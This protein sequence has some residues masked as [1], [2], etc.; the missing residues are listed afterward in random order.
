MMNDSST[1][2][3]F[4]TRFFH[5]LMALGFLW[6]LFTA[7]ARFI[8]EEAAL[9]KAVFKYHGQMGFTILWLAVLR[10]V[11]ALTQRSHRPE[12]N[13][14][15]KLGHFSM[16][17]LMVVVPT[18]AFIR[19]IGGG[20]GFTYWNT[21]PILSASG[22]KTQ[23]M[24]DLGNNFHGLLGWVLFALIVGHVLMA[25]KHRIAGGSED[26]LPRIIGK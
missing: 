26:V 11:W 16:Y 15:T 21:F 23:W 17:L 7:S 18:I 4:V 14:L 19:T 12:N 10:I 8:D 5:W 20:R 22:E 2:Y 6:M 25:I 9:T 1:R 13:A 24:I 3:G